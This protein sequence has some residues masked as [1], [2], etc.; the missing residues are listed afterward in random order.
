VG[1]DSRRLHNTNYFL[2]RKRDGFFDVISIAR[3]IQG[4]S[5]DELLIEHGALYLALERLEAKGW[6]SAAWGNSENNRRARF[7]TLTKA[8]FRHTGISASF[9]IVLLPLRRKG[10]VVMVRVWQ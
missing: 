6:I 1:P 9:A 8:G 2:T 5:G 3:A 7:Y 10:G 4:T